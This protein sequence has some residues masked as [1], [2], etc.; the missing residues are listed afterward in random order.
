M[1]R[2]SPHRLPLLE[3]LRCDFN[4]FV[5]Y[6]KNKPHSCPP[7]KGSRF[8]GPKKTPDFPKWFPFV[9]HPLQ[10][11]QRLGCCNLPWLSAA[12]RLALEFC[13]LFWGLKKKKENN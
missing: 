10:H 7:P 12:Q 2:P 5:F 1:L 3:L 11:P 6:S 4:A 8:D 13:E 9:C